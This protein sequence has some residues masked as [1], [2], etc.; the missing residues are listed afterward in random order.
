MCFFIIFEIFI[1]KYSKRYSFSRNLKKYRDILKDNIFMLF[2]KT[3][4][5]KKSN[6][7]N[8]KRFIIILTIFIVKLKIYFWRKLLQF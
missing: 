3:L 4:L 6:P 8:F 1:N 7:F 5:K 2:E